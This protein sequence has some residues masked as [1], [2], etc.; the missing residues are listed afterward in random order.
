MQY[1]NTAISKPRSEKTRNRG[2]GKTMAGAPFLIIN[3]MTDLSAIEYNNLLYSLFN[4]SMVIFAYV[5]VHRV[6]NCVLR[7]LHLYVLF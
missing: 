5:V 7:F 1:F 4:D 3:I 2:D 6:P